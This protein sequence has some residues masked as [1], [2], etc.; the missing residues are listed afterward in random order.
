M[1]IICTYSHYTRIY[2]IYVINI[3]SFSS[4][5]PA[6]TYLPIKVAAISVADAAPSFDPNATLSTLKSEKYNSTHTCAICIIICFVSSRQFIL[7]I[8]S[9]PRLRFKVLLSDW[10]TAESYRQGNKRI[11]NHTLKSSFN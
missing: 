2:F 8:R 5:I 4:F 9:H 11:L 7:T 6:R 1:C 10:C 3:S